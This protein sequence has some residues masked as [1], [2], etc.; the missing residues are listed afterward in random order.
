MT[1]KSQLATACPGFCILYKASVI[2][3]QNLFLLC[4]GFPVAGSSISY[5][6]ALIKIYYYSYHCSP[7]DMFIYSTELITLWY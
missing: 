2:N 7:R 1:N 6:T 3:S 5:C 4:V